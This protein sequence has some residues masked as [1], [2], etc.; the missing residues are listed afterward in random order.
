MKMPDS[1][2][3]AKPSSGQLLKFRLGR[4]AYFEWTMKTTGGECYIVL[5]SQTQ[6]QVIFIHLF[7]LP[8]RLFQLITKASFWESPG[9]GKRDLARRQSG[10]RMGSYP[11]ATIRLLL[12]ITVT[13]ISPTDL[14]VLPT[15]IF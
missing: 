3:M 1:H 8:K 14:F 6:L 9:K 12:Q 7:P 2:L 13:Y 4:Q 5:H 15:G 10:Q 11:V